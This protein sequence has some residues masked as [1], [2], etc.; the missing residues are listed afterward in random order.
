MH[1][2]RVAVIFQLHHVFIPDCNPAAVRIRI[3]ACVNDSA[4]ER[5][6]NLNAGINRFDF[7]ICFPNAIHEA[8]NC[9]KIFCIRVIIVGFVP[10]FN[11]NRL[12]RHLS[13]FP[14]HSGYII[15]S[16][17]IRRHN[18]IWNLCQSACRVDIFQRIGRIA[19]RRTLVFSG[20][21]V[22]LVQHKSCKIKMQIPE[23]PCIFFFPV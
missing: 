18:H 7:R 5:N 11:K 14:N 16:V 17:R 20:F 1:H 15:R 22:E 21:P 6:R 13:D 12:I 23:V 4:S 10:H 19:C 8:F 9:R 2:D 3:S